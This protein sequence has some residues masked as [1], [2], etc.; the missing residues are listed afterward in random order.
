MKE[1]HHNYSNIEGRSTEDEDEDEDEEEEEKQQENSTADV[2]R[3]GLY[4]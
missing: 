3:N 1:S 2:P 4:T